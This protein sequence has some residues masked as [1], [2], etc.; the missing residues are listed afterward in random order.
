VVRVFGKEQRK[1]CVTW[2]I[3]FS[4]VLQMSVSL[5]TTQEVRTPCL[6]KHAVF[7][8]VFNCIRLWPVCQ[9]SELIEQT[10]N[11]VTY[12]NHSSD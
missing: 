3:Y 1:S 11:A 9:L 2:P 8:L 4:D 10:S 5:I 7:L 12:N 6:G